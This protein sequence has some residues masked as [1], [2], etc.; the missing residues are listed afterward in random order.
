MKNLMR[1][2]LL[3][4]IAGG[5]TF[6]TNCGTDD[7]PE[8]IPFP[9]ISV[10]VLNGS[11]G[12]TINDGGQVEATDLVEFT[13]D[14]TAEGGFNVFRVSGSMTEEFTRNDLQ[15]GEGVTVPR[16]ISL[17]KLLLQNMAHQ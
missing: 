5:F 16:F 14:I 10:N 12:N 3:S 1:I 9:T 2:I 15:L 13:I 11:N 8:P 4:A 17:I 6:L 7:E